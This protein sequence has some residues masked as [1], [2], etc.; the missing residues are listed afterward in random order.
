MPPGEIQGLGAH[1]LM[2]ALQNLFAQSQLQTGKN[3]LATLEY[4]VTTLS[5]FQVSNPW[6]TVYSLLSLAKNTQGEQKFP[7]DY[8]K[9]L[10]EVFKDVVSLTI[11][12]SGSLDIICRS[13][14]PSPTQLREWQANST[15][16]P[17]TVGNLMDMPSWIRDVRENEFGLPLNKVGVQYDRLNANKFV[18]RPGHPIYNTSK[19]TRARFAT[20]DTISKLGQFSSFQD[21]QILAVRG[22][23]L[24]WILQDGIGGP[25]QRG[26]IPSDWAG[27]GSWKDHTNSRPPEAFWRT[28]VGDRDLDGSRPPIWYRRACGHAWADNSTPGLDTERVL[29]N[30]GSSMTAEFITRVRQTVLNRQMFRTTGRWLIGLGPSNSHSSYTIKDG[31]MIY[32]ISGLSVPCILRQVPE[33]PYYY[34]VGECYIHGF[35]DGEEM[36]FLDENVDFEDVWIR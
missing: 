29:E 16:G 20:S 14:A 28:L 9:P 23:H 3:P 2:T 22:V 1:S 24:D 6:D 8:N 11:Q 7:I 15:G 4:L 36:N 12:D 5:V 34:L 17:Q 18:G 27:L 33:K 32:I 31:D 10:F 19:G 13:W 35:M 30:C 21:R 26:N 25:A